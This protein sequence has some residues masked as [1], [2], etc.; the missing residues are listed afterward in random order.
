M[1]HYSPRAYW[2]KVPTP[3]LKDIVFL[4]PDKN[5]AEGIHALI[6]HRKRALNIRDIT[7]D[8]VTHWTRDPGIIKDGPEVLRSYSRIFGS[9]IVLFDIEGSGKSR[10]NIPD[11]TA[12]LKLR[13]V[14]VGF[15][16]SEVIIVDPELENWV[17]GNLNTISSVLG[18]P[19]THPRL[20]RWLETKGFLQ[21]P[22]IKP[23]PPKGAFERVLEEIR[24]PRSS[25][26]YGELAKKLSTRYCIDPGFIKLKDTLT[27]WFPVAGN[28][29]PH[30][31]NT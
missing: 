21:E 8:I 31:F 4:V 16:N 9:A 25:F 10:D 5:W 1:A 26:I 24:K 29:N 15:S 22:S 19:R 13:L 23:D 17:W 30:L 6:V 11:L 2:V 3:N 18:W 27:S 14:T 28:S 7:F 20:N 12:A